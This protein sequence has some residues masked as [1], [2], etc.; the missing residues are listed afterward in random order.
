MALGAMVGHAAASMVPPGGFAPGAS[1]GMP[2][3]AHR[4]AKYAA[5]RALLKSQPN[6]ITDHDHP[7]ARENWEK[8]QSLIRGSTH[9]QG[10]LKLSSIWRGNLV[11]KGIHTGTHR[12]ET[13]LSIPFPFVLRRDDEDGELW[14]QVSKY[15]TASPG[16]GELWRDASTH[17]QGTSWALLYGIQVA[18]GRDGEL[19]TTEVNASVELLTTEGSKMDSARGTVC[20]EADGDDDAEEEGDDDGDESKQPLSAD[21]STAELKRRC[22]EAGVGQSGTKAVSYTHLTLPTILLV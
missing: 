16:L 11:P 5:E 15:M 14:I 17:Y 2:Y 18:E 19:L 4:L 12:I 20:G 21:L 7:S 8:L 1:P 22:E 3:R 6:E 13:D 10:T 9:T